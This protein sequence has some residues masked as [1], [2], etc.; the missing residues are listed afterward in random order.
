MPGAVVRV[1][2]AVACVSLRGQ[3]WCATRPRFVYPRVA[4]ERREPVKGI[5]CLLGGQEGACGW[6]VFYVEADGNEARGSWVGTVRNV[7]QCMHL[8]L[9]ARC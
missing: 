5:L 9:P 3:R 7:I 8:P 6:G 4:E 1:S 2:D